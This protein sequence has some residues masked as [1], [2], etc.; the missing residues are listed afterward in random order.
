MFGIILAAG[1]GTRMNSTLS[2]VLHTV[3]DIPMV[4][5]T[6]QKLLSICYIKQVLI[7]VGENKNEIE[8]LMIENL[9]IMDYNNQ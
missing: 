7:V 4:L 3:N 8:N 9:S 2:K 5:I 6:T 1:K